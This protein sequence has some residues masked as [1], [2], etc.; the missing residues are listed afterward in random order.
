MSVPAPT[1]RAHDLV[2]HLGAYTHISRNRFFNPTVS[3]GLSA[4]A[5]SLRHAQKHPG[6]LTHGFGKNLG[7]SDGTELYE[8]TQ[9]K[10][11]NGIP[12]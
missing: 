6:L 9:P 12:R 8:E 1:K 3:A 2:Q 5:I 11:A 10:Q 7:G 4:G